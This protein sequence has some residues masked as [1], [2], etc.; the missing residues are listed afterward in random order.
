MNVEKLG[1]IFVDNQ[2]FNLDTLSMEELSEL[3][4]KVKST[5]EEKIDNINKVLGKIQN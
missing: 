4:Q 2:I 3:L 5:R 1:E